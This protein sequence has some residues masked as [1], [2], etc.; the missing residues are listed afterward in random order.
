MTLSTLWTINSRTRITVF[1][2]VRCDSSTLKKEAAGSSQTMLNTR[3]EG[4]TCKETVMF[5]ETVLKSQTSQ[6]KDD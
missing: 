2:D 6:I 1:L 5:T 3:K 4:V